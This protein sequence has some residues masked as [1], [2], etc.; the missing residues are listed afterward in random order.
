MK[1]RKKLKELRER[2]NEAT[3]RIKAALNVDSIASDQITDFFEMETNE[4]DFD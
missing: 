2:Y 3:A 4:P 1:E